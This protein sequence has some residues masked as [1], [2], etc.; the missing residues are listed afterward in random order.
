MQED[1]AQALMLAKQSV[2]E[3]DAN[4][5]SA[6]ASTGSDGGEN[7]DNQNGEPT[8]DVTPSGNNSQSSS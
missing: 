7:K 4:G 3:V 5:D 6:T 8:E 2:V 1:H